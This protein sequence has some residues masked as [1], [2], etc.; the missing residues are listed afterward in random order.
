MDLSS[1]YIF[2][3]YSLLKSEWS[4]SFAVLASIE[5]D[6]NNVIIISNNFIEESIEFEWWM[7]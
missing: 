4:K 3:V 5:V 1:S 7:F 6:S 2:S